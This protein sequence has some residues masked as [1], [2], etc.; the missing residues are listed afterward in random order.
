MIFVIERLSFDSLF[1]LVETWFSI[2][3]DRFAFVCL[4]L[5]SGFFWVWF[6]VFLP[7]CSLFRVSMKSPRIPHACPFSL[8]GAYVGSVHNSKHQLRSLSA[9]LRLDSRLLQL[10]DCRG[11]GGMCAVLDASSHTPSTPSHSAPPNYALWC[12]LTVEWSVL[13]TSSWLGQ[14]LHGKVTN[15]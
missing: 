4:C 8:G 10:R 12:F 1:E 9:L 6:W 5:S 3:L 7:R 15:T 14:S 2:L 11:W 13:L